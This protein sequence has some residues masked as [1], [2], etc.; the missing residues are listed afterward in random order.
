MYRQESGGGRAPGWWRSTDWMR[1]QYIHCKRNYRHDITLLSLMEQC[2]TG[3][4]EGG[5]G[6]RTSTT[7][8]K[9]LYNHEHPH[10]SSRARERQ[11]LRMQIHNYQLARLLS[12]AANPSGLASGR[13]RRL[14]IKHKAPEL[15]RFIANIIISVSPQSHCKLLRFTS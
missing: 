15:A 4:R 8:V 6:G 3:A 12:A 13:R 14:H 7:R 5:A 9:Q 1:S 10:C 11:R 2:G